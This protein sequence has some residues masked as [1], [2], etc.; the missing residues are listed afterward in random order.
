M[1]TVPQVAQ[2]IMFQPQARLFGDDVAPPRQL[3][4]T[5]IPPLLTL[6]GILS[7]VMGDE[8]GMVFAAL[9]ASA[10]GLF[11]LWNWLFR[12]APTRFSTLMAMS[13]LLGYGGGTLNTWITLPRGSLTVAALMELPQG[14]LAR[15]MGAVLISTAPLFFL[16]ELYEK[17]LF[18][19]GF[20]LQ[21]DK[22]TRTLIRIGTLGML[23]GYATHSLAFQGPATGGGHVS[24]PGVFLTWLYTPLVAVAVGGFLT[25]EQK[26]DKLLDG[27][28]SLILLLIFSVMGRRVTM[29]TVVEILFMLRLVGYRWKGSLARK[30]LLVL[31]LGAI[32]I[33]CSLTFMLLRIAGASQRRGWMTIEKRVAVASK[34][35]QKGGAYAIAAHATQSNLQKRTFVLSFFANVLDASSRKTPALGQDAFGMLQLSIPSAFYPGKNAYF[36]EEGLVDRQFDLSYGDQPNSI[37]TAGATDFGFIGVIFYPL[38]AILLCRSV[39]NFIARWLRPTPLLFVALSFILMMLVTE[40]TLSGYFEIVRNSGVFGLL[41]QFF[42]TLPVIKRHA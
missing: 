16:G 2:Q 34:L 6:T 39:F 27:L 24:V 15:G 4:I 31:G 19:R 7:W 1:G 33:V 38:I 18:G 11:T 3:Y 5:F 8:L 36:S 42:M 21:I 28:S 30:A 17:P 41:L 13:L 12:E 32:M 23:A 22:R 26:T 20:R 40:T 37:L 10:I 14:V 29:Y 35:V 9:V 25:A